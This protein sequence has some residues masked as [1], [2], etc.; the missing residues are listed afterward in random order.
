MFYLFINLLN[1]TGTHARSPQGGV[2]PLVTFPSRAPA[3]VGSQT[4]SRGWAGLMTSPISR[5]S[6]GLGSARLQGSSGAGGDLAMRTSSFSAA[7]LLAGFRVYRTSFSDANQVFFFTHV[8]IVCEFQEFG[9]RY[10]LELIFILEVFR[11][12]A[13]RSRQPGRQRGSG[14]GRLLP[15][16]RCLGDYINSLS[17]TTSVSQSDFAPGRNF[18]H[19]RTSISS[20]LKN[21]RLS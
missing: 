20:S 18:P 8:Q 19:I 12:R 7:S 21:L 6:E 16:F 17:G 10:S 5:P 2:I 1:F 11:W 15:R 14:V 4:S 13:T 9:C 3:G